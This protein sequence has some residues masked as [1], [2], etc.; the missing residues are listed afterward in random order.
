MDK[1]P[2]IQPEAYLLPT[3]RVYCHGS[4]DFIINV[5]GNYHQLQVVSPNHHMPFS[6]GVKVSLGGLPNDNLE[7]LQIEASKRRSVPEVVR[8]NDHWPHH[9]TIS[10]V[11]RPS[12]L[13]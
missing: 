10:V 2:G 9:F 6:L 1:S 5:V 12:D 7:L 3:D 13:I 11:V 4:Y 8:P